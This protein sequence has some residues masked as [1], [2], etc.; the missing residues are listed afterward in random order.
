VADAA[1]IFASIAMSLTVLNVTPGIEV[2]GLLQLF[3]VIALCAVNLAACTLA[4][5]A[6]IS[7]KDSDATLVLLG[8]AV[9][10]AAVEYS[11]LALFSGSTD[12]HSF[13]SAISFAVVSLSRSVTWNF[14]LLIGVPGLAYLIGMH[15]DER[16]HT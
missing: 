4:K 10:A 14:A 2:A 8:L 12:P 11:L 13:I 5:P 3:I 6:F 16:E 7:L 15:F 1:C 9:L